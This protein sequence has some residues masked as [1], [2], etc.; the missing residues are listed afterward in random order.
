MR[1]PKLIRSLLYSRRDAR[2]ETENAHKL[3]MS[4]RG[5]AKKSSRDSGSEDDCMEVVSELIVNYYKPRYVLNHETQCAYE[6]MDCNCRLIGV[7]DCDIDWKSLK[8]LPKRYIERVKDRNALFPS[9]IRSFKNGVA[10]VSWQLNPDGRY[11]ADDDG[12]GMTDD[13]PFDIYGFIDTDCKVVVPYRAVGSDDEIKKMRFQAEK[14]V[15]T[16]CKGKK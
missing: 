2:L 5:K 6:F 14:V 4:L 9:F 11:W 3:Y 15:A 13:W 7:K 10:E 8:K 16:R 12:Y 1:L